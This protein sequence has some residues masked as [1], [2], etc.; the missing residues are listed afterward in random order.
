MIYFHID[1]V[2]NKSVNGLHLAA[3]GLALLYS[4]F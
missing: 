3:N 1:G 4:F 2:N